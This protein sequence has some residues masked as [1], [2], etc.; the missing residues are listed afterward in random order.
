MSKLNK[1]YKAIYGESLKQTWNKH[2]IQKAKELLLAGHSVK[3]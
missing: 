1:C 2:L 3:K